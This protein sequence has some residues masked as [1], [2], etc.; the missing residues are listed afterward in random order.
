MKRTFLILF[1]LVLATI[2]AILGNIIATY[3]QEQWRLTDPTRIGGV[4]ALF[5]ISFAILLF[6]TLKRSQGKA[7]D[8]G[9]SKTDIRVKQKMGDIE[10]SG[11]I[12]GVEADVIEQPDSMHVEQNARKVSGEMTGLRIGRLGGSDPEK[13]K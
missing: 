6:V 1:G 2:L 3:F 7:D 11:K 8:Q 10:E 13:D 12:T 5:T 4:V 9:S